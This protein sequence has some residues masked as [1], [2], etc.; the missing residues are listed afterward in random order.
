M[1]LFRAHE[2]SRQTINMFVR[3]A[4][5]YVLHVRQISFLS[6]AKL[7]FYLCI[8]HTTALLHMIHI[9]IDGFTMSQY[10]ELQI[11]L[12][13]AQYPEMLELMHAAMSTRV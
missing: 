5:A 2:L 13:S 9:H 8:I 1:L 12:L 3:K 4:L 7:H 11:C 6:S 10:R